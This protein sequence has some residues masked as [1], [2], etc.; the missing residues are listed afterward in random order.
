METPLV[1]TG[2]PVAIPEEC[3]V[4][5]KASHS[6]ALLAERLKRP[7][8]TSPFSCQPSQDVEPSTSDHQTTKMVHQLLMKTPWRLPR[9]ERPRRGSLEST[10]PAW[11]AQVHGCRRTSHTAHRARFC[12]IKGPCHAL[13][14]TFKTPV[15]HP[16][17]TNPQMNL[18]ETSSTG[19]RF[20]NA[21]HASVRPYCGLHPAG[22]KSKR[23]EPAVTQ[24]ASGALAREVR[25]TNVLFIGNP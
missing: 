4:E 25:K 8:G 14:F 24:V 21:V 3:F 9:S 1:G 19:V 10:S 23:H 2:L 6:V 17:L 20:N 16:T 5:G 22:N 15:L 7:P 11:S 18:F 13:S 12:C